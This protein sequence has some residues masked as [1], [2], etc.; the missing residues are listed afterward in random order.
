MPPKT[1]LDAAT[2]CNTQI[3]PNREIFCCQSHSGKPLFARKKKNL[4]GFLIG[5][6]ANEEPG[7]SRLTPILKQW[8]NLMI[9]YASSSCSRSLIYYTSLHS[10]TIRSSRPFSPSRLPNLYRLPA[11]R[12]AR[13]ISP[14][15]CAIFRGARQATRP[16]THTHIHTHTHTHTQ[17]LL[18]LVLF[19]CAYAFM[20]MCSYVCVI[21]QASCIGLLM[22]LCVLLCVCYALGLLCRPAY[23]SVYTCARLCMR[24]SI[25]QRW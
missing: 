2:S 9:L 14:L 16:H 4:G 5:R 23:M 13:G 12:A 7:R 8:Q 21:L 18:V 10:C 1:K 3:H 19:A 25:L 24:V 11:F 22:Y 17:T 15:H 6:V 20:C